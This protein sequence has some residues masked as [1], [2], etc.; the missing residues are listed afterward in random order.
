MPVPDVTRF[1]KC[2]VAALI[3][4][5]V[6][7]WVCLLACLHFMYPYLPG[8]VPSKR[9]AGAWQLPPA[10]KHT[11]VQAVRSME[12]PGERKLPALFPT[13]EENVCFDF[14]SNQ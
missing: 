3:F 14:C 8:G 9:V 2:Q 11:C 1:L 6:L 4:G 10:S 7:V 12:V 13:K 5:F